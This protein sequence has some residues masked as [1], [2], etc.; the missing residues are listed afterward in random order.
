M[1]LEGV[2][3][4]DQ[5]RGS[6][7]GDLRGPEDK[8]RGVGDFEQ[9]GA[10]VQGQRRGRVEEEQTGGL[11][12]RDRGET[13]QRALVFQPSGP[14]RPA[15][16]FS[17]PP[18]SRTLGDRRSRSFFAF[19]PGKCEE[20]DRGFTLS[21]ALL[22][23]AEILVASGQHALAFDDLRFAEELTVPQQFKSELARKKEAC[24]K[25]IRENEKS[26]VLRREWT[27]TE[28]KPLPPLTEG[29][30]PGIPGASSLL[31]MEETVAAGKRA[32]AAKTI[33]PG[34]TLVVEPPIAAALLPDFFGTHC[35]HCFSRFVAPVG[36]PNCSG[37]AF[38]GRKCRDAAMSTYHKY[39]CKI[40]ALLIG[41]GMSV[42]SMLALRM[43]TQNGPNKCTEIR[44]ALTGRTSN[45][46]ED[47]NARSSTETK[48]S[49]SAKRRS[50]KKKWRDS[51]RRE[52]LEEEI[53]LRAYDLVA[54]EKQRSAKDFFERSLMAAFL[55]R[56]LQ[57]VGFFEKPTKDEETP[58]EE[59][60][61]VAA[62][63]SK[64]LQLLQFNA[65]EVFETRLGTEHWFRG[66]KPVYLGVAVYPTVARFNH[67]CYP[68]VTRYFVGRSIV[69]R[70]IRRLQPGDVVAEN[71]GPI[72][73]K[74]TLKE[75]QNTLAGRYWFRC[76]CTACREDWPLFDGLSNDLV[77]LRSVVPG[78]YK[79]TNFH[80]IERHFSPQ[81]SYRGMHQSTR[82]AARSEQDDQVLL[83][84]TRNRFTRI[85]RN[86]TRMRNALRSRFRRDGPR[87]GRDRF[88]GVPR[89]S[90]QVPPSGGATPQGHSPGGNRGQR[91]HGRQRQRLVATEPPC[92][93]RRYTAIDNNT[94]RNKCA[95]EKEK[96][97][98]AD[99]RIIAYLTLDRGEGR[100]IRD[101]WRRNKIRRS[102]REI[103]RFFWHLFFI[104]H[105]FREKIKFRI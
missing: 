83:V 6:N 47:G 90:G 51:Q 102:V 44:H 7:P 71:Y 81:V 43:V 12:G 62:L 98:V 103:L 46:G 84:S 18:P 17:I 73:T 59:E 2:R 77:R 91:L 55:L 74:R 23:R 15:D 21:L 34:D 67:D 16:R 88:A 57:R 66:S 25:V 82:N 85:T 75:R 65:H 22:A 9:D 93:I 53:D 54:H 24:E 36:C 87:T 49:K 69:I 31:E 78:S 105:M 5:R 3:A 48:P 10:L 50:R 96:E 27:T 92:L 8:L 13:H 19:V 64:H 30:N 41:S 68:A 1:D 104:M 52:K 70:A 29:E 4:T 42:L 11:R 97:N 38:C 60:I 100:G 20:V 45:E 61:G 28:S 101:L 63:L 56:C 35:Q 72:F 86:G 89:R 40:L 58:N 94:K 32:I 80:L 95:I 79:I 14:S 26:L 39:E 99:A 33:V 37:V 76:E